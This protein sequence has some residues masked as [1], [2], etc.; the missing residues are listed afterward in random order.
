MQNR[1][2]A[3]M[4]RITNFLI[5][6]GPST[7]ENAEHHADK[8]LQFNLFEYKNIPINSFC[9]MSHENSSFKMC[10]QLKWRKKYI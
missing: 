8:I 4:R 3:I 5:N 9:S 7:I 1:N 6:N 10:L 2:A